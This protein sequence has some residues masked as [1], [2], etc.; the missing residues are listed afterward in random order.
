MAEFVHTFQFEDDSCVLRSPSTQ[1]EWDDY[2]MIRQ[3]EIVARYCPVD[4]QYDY[5]DPEEQAALNFRFILVLKAL[6][7]V[8]GTLRIDLL[9]CDESSLRWVAI[10]QAFQK[11]GYGTR[12]LELGQKFVASQNRKLIR[13]PAEKTS[14][15]F[16]E[17]IGFVP[18]D[19][20]EAPKD[21]GN[22]FLAKAL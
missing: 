5:E 2:H 10:A 21:S 16:Y 6:Q 11:K 20:P 17:K 8:I 7:T 14:S 15:G 4:Y 18:T 9:S 22:V 1:Q 3:A 13:I 12:M 19:W